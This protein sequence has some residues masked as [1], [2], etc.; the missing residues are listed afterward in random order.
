VSPD[1]GTCRATGFPSGDDG[2]AR[3]L[4]RVAVRE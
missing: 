4:V 3:A 2:H 1:L